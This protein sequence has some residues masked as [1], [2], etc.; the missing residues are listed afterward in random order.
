MLV[1]IPIPDVVT[2]AN[3]GGDRL[4]R[5]G[6]AG[7]QIFIFCLYIRRRPYKHFTNT[8]VSV[9]FAL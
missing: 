5:L 3:F 8:V 1:G 7:G 6:V 4:K 9:D 2:G